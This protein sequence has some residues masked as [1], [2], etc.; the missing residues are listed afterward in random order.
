MCIDP[1]LV[2]SRID[3]SSPALGSC[4]GCSRFTCPGGAVSLA[5][6]SNI[7]IEH[8][9]SLEGGKTECAAKADPVVD[10]LQSAACLASNLHHVFIFGAQIVEQQ[11]LIRFIANHAWLRRLQAEAAVLAHLC[12]HAIQKVT[13]GIRFG[14]FQGLQQRHV[15]DHRPCDV[16]VQNST[17]DLFGHQHPVD[18]TILVASRLTAKVTHVQFTS[19]KVHSHRVV[20]CAHHLVIVHHDSS[21]LATQQIGESLWQ[22]VIDVPSTISTSQVLSE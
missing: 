22:F 2:M 13:H 10:R 9:C 1:R 20:Q 19:N 5:L 21:L 15:H 3:A 6:R 12:R 18:A 7:E 11:I 8:F 4:D 16:L 17:E 14:D